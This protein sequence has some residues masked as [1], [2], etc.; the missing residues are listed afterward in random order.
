[1]DTETPVDAWYVWFGVGVV[2]VG[3]FGIALG[4]P[5]TPPPDAP[6]AANTVEQTVVSPAEATGTYHHD[7]TEARI[8]ERRLW[9][10]ADGAEATAR[11]TYGRMVPAGGNERLRAVLDGDPPPDVYDRNTE[12]DAWA[13][14]HA[15]VETA[16]ASAADPDWRAADGT[17]RARTFEYPAPD[18]YGESRVTLV[19]A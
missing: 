15:D 9:L 4:L 12:A 3:L 8:G 13:A 16:R 7:A 10:R 5:S 18:H 11:I 6:A 19:V 17:V 1:M 2:S 14:F